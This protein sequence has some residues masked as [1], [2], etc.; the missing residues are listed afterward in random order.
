M[1]RLCLTHNVTTE[2]IVLKDLTISDMSHPNWDFYYTPDIVTQDTLIDKC[3]HYK[4]YRYDCFNDISIITLSN[5]RT[6]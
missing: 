3:K 1:K 2:D 5:D 6:T 4:F